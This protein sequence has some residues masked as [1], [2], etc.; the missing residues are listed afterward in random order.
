MKINSQYGLEIFIEKEIIGEFIN[1][2]SLHYKVGYLKTLNIRALY[3]Y[4][5]SSQTDYKSP[6][7]YSNDVF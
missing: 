5:L 2:V 1:L 4:A 6:L 3:E 7:L